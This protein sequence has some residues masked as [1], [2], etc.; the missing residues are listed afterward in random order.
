MV[1][2]FCW[3]GHNTAE[4]RIILKQCLKNKMDSADP[5]DYHDKMKGIE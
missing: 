5:Y 2:E 3:F 1:S 4:E